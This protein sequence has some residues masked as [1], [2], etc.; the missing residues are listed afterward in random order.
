MMFGDPS[1]DFNHRCLLERI[2]SDYRGWHLTCN[3][4]QWDTVQLCV[5]NRR[6]EIGCPRTAG[7]HHHANLTGT[8]GVTLS[9]ECPALFVTRQNG[10]DRVAETRQ[11]L[12]HWHATTAWIRK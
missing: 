10:S 9:G 4:E 11:R 1:A 7:R 12:M 2:A 6:H 5:R 3:A 8:P